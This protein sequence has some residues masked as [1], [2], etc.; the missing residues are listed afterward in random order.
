MKTRDD[1][2]RKARVK[3]TSKRTGQGNPAPHHLDGFWPEEHPNTKAFLNALTAL[4]CGD[5]RV[6]LPLDWT[7]AAGKA[8]EIFNELVASNERIG[9]ELVQLRHAVA[10]TKTLLHA[11]TAL[12][13]GDF[14]V[15]LPLDWV[16]IAGKTADPGC[17]GSGYRR[18]IGGPGGRP[19]RRRHLEGS[20]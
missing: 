15:R 4:K 20:D 8:A 18:E 2:D 7:G 9:Q 17:A 13:S 14:S 19:G 16:G 5:F 3:A 10:D 6:R 1:S 11:L 12:K